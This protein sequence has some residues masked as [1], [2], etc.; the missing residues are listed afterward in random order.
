MR[1]SL[2]GYTLIELLIVVI[3]IG[4]IT[5]L[6]APQIGQSVANIATSDAAS[7][8]MVSF[9]RGLK[10]ELQQSPRTGSPSR[11]ETQS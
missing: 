7:D 6:A 5:A 4:I 1:R 2:P 9:R 10:L 8:V 3:L 11:A